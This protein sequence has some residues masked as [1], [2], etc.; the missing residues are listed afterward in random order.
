MHK[1]SYKAFHTFVFA[2]LKSQLYFSVFFNKFLNYLTFF[3]L[4]HLISTDFNLFK[5]TYFEYNNSTTLLSIPF[6]FS[7]FKEPSLFLYSLWDA[8]ENQ[9]NI[10]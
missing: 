10:V 1:E 6:P 3:N 4:F 9:L 5:P 2:D 8:L 7:L